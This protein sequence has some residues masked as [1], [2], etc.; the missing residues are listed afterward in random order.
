MALLAADTVD[1]KLV[2]QIRALAMRY[3]EAFNKQPFAPFLLY[4]WYFGCR[5]RADLLSSRECIFYELDS[6]AEKIV[7][8]TGGTAGIGKATAV[9]FA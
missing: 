5:I 9:A 4:R 8:I 6:F 3:E 7:L 1:P 2:E